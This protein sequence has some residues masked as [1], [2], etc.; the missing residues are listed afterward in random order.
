M[1]LSKKLGDYIEGDFIWEGGT[2]GESGIFNEYLKQFFWSWKKCKAQFFQVFAGGQD[3]CWLQEISCFS[4]LFA[5]RDRLVGRASGIDLVYDYI[6]PEYAEKLINDLAGLLY[7][8]GMTMKCII[9]L[10]CG[11]ELEKKVSPMT[12]GWFVVEHFGNFR[13]SL[14]TLPVNYGILTFISKRPKHEHSFCANGLFQETVMSCN[15]I[16]QEKFYCN[17]RCFWHS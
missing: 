9:L 15:Y 3:C 4:D 7:R 13:G 6:W 1:D 16:V 8:G 17:L 11:G 14:D 5:E 12:W 2:Y 10:I